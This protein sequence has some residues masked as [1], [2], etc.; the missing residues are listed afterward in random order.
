MKI[1]FISGGVG[2]DVIE[3][4]LSLGELTTR[5]MGSFEE[6]LKA[7]KHYEGLK[8]N[9]SPKAMVQKPIWLGKALVRNYRFQLFTK[10]MQV[11][12]LRA[13]GEN[14]DSSAFQILKN[15]HTHHSYDAFEKELK[16]FKEQMRKLLDSAEDEQVREIEKS[17]GLIRTIRDVKR[18][19][20]SVLR[21]TRMDARK[22]GERFKRQ[23]QQQT[24]AQPR[25]LKPAFGR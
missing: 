24:A 9:M 22:E 25:N 8:G 7:R 5:I 10:K 16:A 17:R 18:R 23:V 11:E 13:V 20:E 14:V 15:L 3:T 19:M 12:Y 1:P 4:G 2:K 21:R 6:Y